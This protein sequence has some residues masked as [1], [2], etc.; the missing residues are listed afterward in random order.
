MIPDFKDPSYLITGNERQQRAFDVLSD[1][2]MFDVLANYDPVLVGTIPIEL[3]LP[4]SDL[5]IICFFQDEKEFH[6]ILKIHYGD[7]LGFS[8]RQTIKQGL[9][10]CIANFEHETFAI[11][12]FGQPLPTAEQMAFRHL[13]REYE[14][15][16]QKGELFRREVIQLKQK[17]LSTESAFAKLL[18]IEGDPYVGLLA[19][20]IGSEP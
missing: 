2:K 16:Q 18:G 10:T 1:L 11:E 7:A 20:Q 13:I 9:I 15:L 8:L 14:I 3:D 17:G 6:S 4:T 19:Y 5:D 12:V